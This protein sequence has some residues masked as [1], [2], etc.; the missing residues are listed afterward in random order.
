MNEYK[1]LIV[2]GG[3]TTGAAIDGI[4]S[5]DKEGRIGLITAEADG[6]YDRPPL[7]KDL[8]KGDKQVADIRYEI[9][10]GV[11]LFTER[12]VTALDLAQKQV[13]DAE[14]RVYRYDKLLLATGGAPN[15]LSFDE[16]NMIIYYRT[17]R[18]YQ[19]LQKLA[20]QYN[21][22]TV[23]GGG[24]IGSELAA[25]LRLNGKEVTLLF[26]EDAIC[27]RLFPPDVAGFLNRYYESK[28]VHVLPGTKVREIQ[29]SHGAYRLL[30]NEG[31]EI[32][33]EIVVA[34]IGIHPNTQLA[35]MA[36]L[37]V[38]DGIVVNSALQTSAPDIYAAGDA[39]KFTDKLLGEWR[40]VEH[41]DNALSMGK[42]AGRAMAGANISYDYSPMFYSDLF[43]IGYEAVGELNAGLDILI[44]WQEEYEKGVIYYLKDQ[45]VRGV[46]L[47]NVWDQVE[48]AR[49]LIA[50]GKT[51]RAEELRGQI[52]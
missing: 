45:K 4:R 42:A 39:A 30:T 9:P 22:F 49:Q 8:W 34:G 29:G 41:E 33:T 2:G 1:Y 14:D 44:D 16:E 31:A 36:G 17:L 20:A 11:E 52:G 35:E 46:L 38:D 6:P 19:Q 37:Q 40:R 5:V 18:D 25:A 48:A 26:P 15:R 43:D 27:T 51:W 3:M 23:I 12:Q 21:K 32:E 13:I 24:F 7:T 47:W 28:G 10:A 50:T